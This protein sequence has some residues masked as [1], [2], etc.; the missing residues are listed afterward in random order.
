[1][2]MYASPSSRRVRR[3]VFIFP[4]LA[5]FGFVAP[6]PTHAQ[7]LF[8]A[9]FNGGTIE[10]FNAAGVGT[11]LNFIGDISGGLTFNSQGDL[12]VANGYDIE[13][14]TPQGV[15]TQFNG[16]NDTVYTPVGLAINSQGNLFVGNAGTNTIQEFN[17]QGHIIN[18]LNSNSGTGF[19]SIGDPAGLAFDSHG[20]LFVANAVSGNIVEFS[21]QGSGSQFNITDILNVPGTLQNEPDALAFNS[22]GNLFVANK[23]SNTIDEFNSAGVGSQFNV[24]G[25][26]NGPTGIA[27]NN[28]GDLFVCNSGD[29][30]IEEFNTRGVGTRFDV[31]GDLNNP[32]GLAFSPDIA[33]AVPEPSA[34]ALLT[35]GIPAFISLFLYSR[36]RNAA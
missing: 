28:V 24:S 1:M 16:I 6:L 12:F 23:E 15:A 27:F 35:L 5:A 4:V 2:F 32:T 14:V 3:S 17:S 30:S 10:K 34:V 13:E 31:S 8:V 22:Q 11:Q 26:V 18:T 25:D 36:R 33:P 20:N 29:N 19:G 7:N 9:N 21:P